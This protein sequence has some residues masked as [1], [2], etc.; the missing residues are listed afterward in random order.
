MGFLQCYWDY[1][2][3][4]QQQWRK[5]EESKSASFC[6]GCFVG[7]MERKIQA[8]LQVYEENSLKTLFTS[9][10]LVPCHSS[11]LSDHFRPH[12]VVVV[13]QHLPQYVTLLKELMEATSIHHPDY[14]ATRKA[15]FQ[16]KV[17]VGS[18]QPESF[19]LPP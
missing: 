19:V 16:A 10:L 1:C 2:S 11:G 14:A 4:N 12:L 13:V 6:F 5:I 8:T 7:H 15:Y 3:E 18:M 9:P 17:I